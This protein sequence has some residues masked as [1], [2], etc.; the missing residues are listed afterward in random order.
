MGTWRYRRCGVDERRLTPSGTCFS[1][2]A[3]VYSVVPKQLF[4]M[5]KL[6]NNILFIPFSLF[7][8]V[9]LSGL[10]VAVHHTH[11][12]EYK[13]R[14][15]ETDSHN[16]DQAKLNRTGPSTYHEVHFV[17]LL[18]DDS[19]NT[20]SRTE[21]ISSIAHFIVAILP[22]TIKFSTP[23]ISSIQSPQYQSSDAFP[24]RDK[25]VL[26]CSFLI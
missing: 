18:S 12:I 21:G 13:Q 11:P 6:R 2:Y 16:H 24:A 17:K 23:I 3:L 7:L 5:R 25:C 22:R 8:S 1:S 20:S 10:T 9:V 19:F 4:F 14:S 15:S 26:F